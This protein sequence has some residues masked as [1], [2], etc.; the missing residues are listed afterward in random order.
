MANVQ[1][2]KGT[3]S[4]LNSL[5][6]Y[7]AGAFYLTEDSDR[8]YYAQSSNELVYLNKNI[9]TVNNIQALP[10]IADAYVGDVYYAVEENVLCTRRTTND[11]SWTQI[12]QVTD[13]YVYGKEISFV[14]RDPKED[15]AQGSI[16]YDVTLTQEHKDVKSSVTSNF[17]SAVGTLSIPVGE[18]VSSGVKVS[19]SDAV[20]TTNKTATLSL[21]G[22]GA[23]SSNSS[24]VISYGNGLSVTD[25]AD[26]YKVDGTTYNLS[27]SFTN[28]TENSPAEIKVA[29]TNGNIEQDDPFILK[30]GT[31][32]EFAKESQQGKDDKYVIKHKEYSNFTNPTNVSGG[33]ISSATRTFDVIS[34]AEVENGHIKSF[35]TKTYTLPVDNDNWYKV[36]EVEANSEGKI[37]VKML[38]QSNIASIAA[39][40]SGA[41]LYYKVGN[42]TIYNQGDLSNYLAKKTDV[43]DIKNSLKTLNALTYQGLIDSDDSYEAIVKSATNKN[44]DVYLVSPTIEKITYN[45]KEIARAGDLIIISGAEDSI[46]G[47]IPTDKFDFT[48][49]PSGNEIDTTYTLSSSSNKIVLTDK[50]AN[51]SENISLIVDEEGVTENLNPLSI[52]AGNKANTIKIRHNSITTVNNNQTSTPSVLDYSAAFNVITG[53]ENDAY[54]HITKITTSKYQLPELKTYKLSGNKDNKKV[55]LT[56]GNIAV[57]SIAIVQGDAIDVSVSVTEKEDQNGN[58][59]VF[60]V[61]HADVSTTTNSNDIKPGSIASGGSIAYIKNITVNAQGHVSNIEYAEDTLFTDTTYSLSGKVEKQANASVVTITDTLTNQSNVAT[62]SVKKIKSDS[63]TLA[64]ENKNE[65]AINLTWGSF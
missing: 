63:L 51:A 21:G 64:V 33:D 6:S 40:E 36:S 57:G 42:D 55:S 5:T 58:D 8:L 32:I 29:L 45:E 11:T 44:G 25:T 47:Y 60:T 12:N 7:E 10:P 1:F 2:L 56:T 61:T 19:L 46:T 4:K 13:T 9:I 28:A 52:T 15:E 65:I 41:S 59:T 31:D 38:D 22:A 53:V 20:N 35:S 34:G 39:V 14:K 37:V 17:A 26:G 54:G 23:D 48:H 62:S 50:I 43:D 27:N 49:V 3:Q 16:Y 18:I 24:V 30:N